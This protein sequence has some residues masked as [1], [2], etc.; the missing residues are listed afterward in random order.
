MNFFDLL[1]KLPPLPD[2]FV[3]TVALLTSVLVA[4][5]VMHVVLNIATRIIKARR[6]V[7]L[8]YFRNIAGLVEY[9]A[10]LLIIDFELPALPL[11][12]IA[13][14]RFHHILV[15]AFVILFGWITIVVSDLAINR[16]VGRFNIHQEDN[17]LARKA[18]TQM[19]MLKRT[20][21]ITIIIVT[22]GLALMSFDSV[23]QY[24]I[25]IFASAGV[26]GLAVGLAA[27]P[28]LSNII[29]GIQLA[30]TQP[31]RIDDAVVVE[32]EWGWI[33]EFTS[34]YVVIRLWDLR[35]LIVPLSYFLEKP[36]QN[37][38]RV[39]A[40]LIGSVF[41]YVDFDVDVAKIRVK[42]EQLARGSPLWDGQTVNLQVTN[43]SDHG[44][45]LRALVSARTSSRV[46]D[47]R[48]EIREKLNDWLRQE[49]P[50]AFPRGRSFAAEALPRARS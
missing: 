28:V 38:T 7:L 46:W 17:L 29:A 22:A 20:L 2:W 44:L 25:S 27:R 47:L 18:V 35:R 3:A 30:I 21:E 26:A 34:T 14:M 49:Y 24:G 4:L 1:S 37:W 42:L 50:Q 13:A 16:Y 31:I 19:R 48:C 40:S 33:E 8:T 32:G 43:T 5:L 11:G 39:T 36:F 6:P 15:A 45:E 41:F 9:A 10:I 12:E 23:R